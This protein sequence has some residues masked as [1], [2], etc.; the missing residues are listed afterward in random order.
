MRFETCSVAQ[1]AVTAQSA[2]GRFIGKN[3]VS[4]VSHVGYGIRGMQQGA[5]IING[6]DPEAAVGAAVE[7]GKVFV[8]QNFTVFI[9]ADLHF[10]VELVSGAVMHK[11]FFPVQHQPDRAMCIHGQ[12]TRYYFV[13]T[14]AGFHPESAAHI[15]RDHSHSIH[16]Q[17]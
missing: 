16:G 10:M 5:V 3:A 7:N 9:H 17:L 8:R 15:W 11:D 6:G 12:H 14:G 1:S 2:A 13:R 4:I